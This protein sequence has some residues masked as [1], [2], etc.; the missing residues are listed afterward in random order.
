M[1]SSCTVGGYSKYSSSRKSPQEIG[2][3]IKDVGNPLITTQNVLLKNWD[4]T[5]PKLTPTCMVLK[6]ADN[7]RRNQDQFHDKFRGP[8]SDTVDM[9]ALER[10]TTL[11]WTNHYKI[12]QNK[13]DR[14]LLVPYN[15]GI[16][17]LR[18][19]E[20]IPHTSGTWNKLRVT[21]CPGLKSISYGFSLR[22]YPSES[23]KLFI[24]KLEPSPP[25]FLGLVRSAARGN[26]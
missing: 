1:H 20:L 15:I 21:G 24:R 12:T 8:R 10:I 6:V 16:K 11:K 9:V 19:A 13:M 14:I 18:F 23:N 5:E 22:N 3:R 17:V 7:D 25:R 26:R 2:R 4:G